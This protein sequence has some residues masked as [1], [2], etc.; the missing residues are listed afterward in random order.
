MPDKILII[1]AGLPGSGKTTHLKAFTQYRNNCVYLDKDTVALGL[2]NGREMF[3]DYYN[4]YVKEQSYETIMLVALDNLKLNKV[5]VVEGFFGDK[6][7]KPYLQRILGATDYKIKL[8]YFH[9]T[10]EKEHER[11]VS[12]GA[13]RDSD[14][15][16]DKFPH[17]RRKNMNTHLQTLAAL[18]H[19]VI[20]TENDTDLQSNLRMIDD[21]INMPGSIAAFALY[22]R[23]SVNVNQQNADG[24]ALQFKNLLIRYQTIEV[25]NHILQPQHNT[26]GQR[27]SLA[28]I[29]CTALVISYGIFRR[30]CSNDRSLPAE[31]EEKK[32][33]P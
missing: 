3:G 17:Y 11:L 13:E 23:I 22:P 15:T 14:K 30:L 6:F 12:R 28:G 8:I 5:A 4:S 9:C 26:H 32:L 16:G 1:A 27:F 29:S 20:D 31:R 25:L 10:A 7:S 19:L 24:D 2:L 33:Q 18:P 21:Y